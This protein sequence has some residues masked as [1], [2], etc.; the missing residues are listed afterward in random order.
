MCVCGCSI[1]AEKKVNRH[2]SRYVYYHCTRKKRALPCYEKCVE[3]A[4]L[5]EQILELIESISL[6]QSKVQKLLA[7]IE[8]ERK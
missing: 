5:E 1:T 3:G 4:Q 8:E 6:D 7:M 2:G